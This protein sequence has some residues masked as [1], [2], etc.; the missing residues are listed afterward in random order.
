MNDMHIIIW[1]FPLLFIL[2]DFEEII[3]IKYWIQKNENYLQ[4]IVPSR[5]IPVINHMKKIS[6]AAFAF[7]AA[8]EYILIL[9]I[10]IVSFLTNWYYLWLGCFIAFVLHMI[11]HIF[12]ALFI[13]RYIPS[14]ATSLICTPISIA[15]LVSIW[16]Q[17]IFSRIIFY[18]ILS[19]IIMIGNLVFIHWL[20]GKLEDNFS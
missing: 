18:S 4:A 6:T 7:G 13:K 11:V 3:F 20:M 19:C 8:E 5:F 1:S 9:I 15:I 2:H 17:F 16:N 14:L 12:Q 10:C